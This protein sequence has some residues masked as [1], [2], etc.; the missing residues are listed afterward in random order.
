[1]AR[2]IATNGDTPD[3]S[4]T[5]Q[6]E[7]SVD[8][9]ATG[10]TITDAAAAV[11]VSRQTVSEWVNHHAGVQAALNARRQELWTE[12]ADA[13]RSLVPKALEILQRELTGKD[14]LAAAV[15][16]LKAAGLYGTAPPVGPTEPEE[17]AHERKRKA[18][19]RA[20]DDF[21]FFDVR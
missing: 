14:A 11:S 13:L 21:T 10:T 20:L 17:I 12:R 18:S 19:N 6:Q 16:V 9:L 7:A 2:R 8:L 3:Y 5:P 1:M 15:H 4:L